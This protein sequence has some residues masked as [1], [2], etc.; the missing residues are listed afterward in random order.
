MRFYG[1]AAVIVLMLSNCSPAAGD[2]FRFD[3]IERGQRTVSLLAGYGENHKIPDST[4]V[5]F[6][7]N[8]LKLR[9]GRFTSP[10]TEVSYE[11]IGGKQTKDLDSYTVSAL[12]GYR[13]YFAVRGKTALSYDLGIG[14]IHFGDKIEGQATR[15][16]FTEQAGFTLQ[17]SVGQASAISLEYR[18]CHASNAGIKEPNVGINSSVIM[19]GYTWYK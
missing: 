6:G 19:A 9:Y 7:T 13:R 18:F 3:S 17:H 14:I 16:N 8:E 11:F 5:R 4:K 2:T 10:R 1:Y 12:I 15:N